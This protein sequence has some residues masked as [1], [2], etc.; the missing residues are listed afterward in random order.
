LKK[1]ERYAHLARGRERKGGN[2]TAASLSLLRFVCAFL[3][4]L[5]DGVLLPSLL[6]LFAMHLSPQL[7]SSLPFDRECDDFSQPKTKTQSFTLFSPSLSLS[8]SLFAKL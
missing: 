2:K 1:C 6:I 8:L 4:F 7:S 5:I 3:P